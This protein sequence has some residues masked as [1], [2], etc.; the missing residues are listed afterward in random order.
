MISTG[1]EG[2]L[3]E[4]ENDCGQNAVMLCGWKAKEGMAHFT[5]LSG[6]H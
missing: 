2:T 6:E 4:M 5:A 3:K 1:G